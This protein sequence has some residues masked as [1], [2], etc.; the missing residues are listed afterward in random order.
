MSTSLL[1]LLMKN[2]LP[3]AEVREF[4][5]RRFSKAWGE[6]VIFKI[7][8]I[9]YNRMTEIRQIEG[10]DFDIHLILA[11]VVEPD[12]K[13][14][15]LQAKLGVL[16][17]VDCVKKLLTPGEITELVYAIEISNGYRVINLEEIKKK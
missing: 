6:D 9:G 7:K 16:T 8:P 15:K 3:K 4:K 14:K 10:N 2:D 17:P 11:G 12:F 5:V 1:D 13:D